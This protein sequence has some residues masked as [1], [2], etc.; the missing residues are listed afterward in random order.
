MYCEVMYLKMRFGFDQPKAEESME[1]EEDGETRQFAGVKSLMR[2]TCL[3][4]TIVVELF[5][6]TVCIKRLMI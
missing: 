5:A 1:E 3:K 2:L 6:H 4:T